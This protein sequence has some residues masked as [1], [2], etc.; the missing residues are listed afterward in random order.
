MEAQEAVLNSLD[1]EY[2]ELRKSYGD[3]KTK[4]KEVES[5]LAMREAYKDLSFFPSGNGVR[6]GINRRV[7]DNQNNSVELFCLDIY[8]KTI[9]NGFEQFITQG[10]D[11]LNGVILSIIEGIQDRLRQILFELNVHPDY[12]RKKNR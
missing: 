11:G 2:A 8:P 12:K 10:C 7:L 4:Y 3:L 6:I 1:T 9:S 5:L